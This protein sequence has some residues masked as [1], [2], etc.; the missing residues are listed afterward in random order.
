MERNPETVYKTVLIDGRQYQFTDQL[1]V[2]QALSKAGYN[3]SHFPEEGRIYAPCRTGGCWSC[4]VLIDGTLKPSCVTTLKDGM[5]IITD[6][7]AI[8]AMPPLRQ[9][10]AVKAH[11]V[12][13]V[14]TP[15]TLRK[16]YQLTSGRPYYTEVGAFTQGCVLRCPTCQNWPYTYS[17]RGTPLTPGQA[18]GIIDSKARDY[19]LKR[20]AF[21]GGESTINRRWLVEVL[22]KL[23]ALNPD[24]INLHVDTNGALLTPDYIEQLI[25]AG[26]TD[27]GVDLKSSRL[28][29]YQKV[30]GIKHPAF[31][32]RF[33]EQSWAGVEYLLKNCAGRIFVG[34]GIVYNRSLVPLEEVKEIAGR[35]IELNPSVQV[36]LLDY[37]PEFRQR[38]IFQP[39]AGEMFDVWKTLKK[40]GLECVLC[41]TTAGYYG[42]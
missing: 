7:K 42:P 15:H 19:N 35:I 6:R 30:T 22:K 32:R 12:G 28:E 41:Q 38:D 39:S 4:T 25:A 11:P 27:I 36:C 34:L 26:M 5:E 29:T 40:M 20:I 2:L 1:T 17:S 21:T 10:A 24:G 14:G 31:S 37:R 18:A 3:V 33:F 16:K 9:I 13:G 8:E 23:K